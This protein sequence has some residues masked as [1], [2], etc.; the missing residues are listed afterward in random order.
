MK[1][2]DLGELTGLEIAVIGMA[3]RFPGAADLDKF[4]R[5]LQEG[6]ESI[7][8]FSNREL[9]EAGIATDIYTR[10]DY[11][12]AKG[13][14]ENIEYFDA[15]FFGYPPAEAT[16]MNP[17]MR[18]LHE[19]VWHAFEHAGIVPSS[20][21]GLIG[22]YVGETLSPQWEGLILL[23]SGIQDI[24]SL[25]PLLHRAVLSTS[26]S[27]KLNLH[28]PSFSVQTACSTSLVAIHLACQGL[29]SGDCD[30]AAAGGV[31][32]TLPNKC[33]YIYKKGMINSPDGHCRAFD[34]RAEGTVFGN[35]VGTVVLK[36]LE[37]AL[38]G[39]DHII[40]VIRGS[41]INN[42]GNRKA[43]LS[44]PSIDGEIE[45]I[46]GALNAAGAS[47]DSIGY[48]EAHGTG[49]AVGD[50]I[51]VEALHSVFG[52][53]AN[54]RCALGS[55][56][57][58]IGHLDVAAGVAGFIKTALALQ[59][60]QIPA[61]LNFSQPNSRIDFSKGPFYINTSLQKWDQGDKPLRAGVSSFGIGGTNAHVILEEFIDNRP[62]RKHPGQRTAS[63]IVL[64][65]KT[66]TA[67][68]QTSKNL[69]AY[70]E[71]NPHIDLS[72]A[73]YTL[74][75]GRT[76]FACRQALTAENRN[77]AINALAY[78]D[79]TKVMSGS[80]ERNQPRRPVI[81]LFPG[82]GA[83]YVSM[84]EE[85][86]RTEPVFRDTM[87]ECFH[88][89]Q[90][91]TG[92][93]FKPYLFPQHPSEPIPP[94][95]QTEIAQPLIFTIEYALAQLLKSWGIEPE[96]SIGH[97]I[98]EYTAACISG[99]MTLEVALKLI[100]SRGTL[101]QKCAP[102]GMIG[103]PLPATEAAALIEDMEL[104]LAAENSPAHCVVSGPKNA[105][106]E[107]EN[108]LAQAGFNG[109]NLHT[110]H[111]FHSRMMEPIVDKFRNIVEHVA[112]NPPV[113][114]FISNASGDWI[115]DGQA[116]DPNYWASHIVNT[117]RF[118]DGMTEL[119]K[120]EH[121]VFLE[122]G[123][124]RTLSTFAKQNPGRNP[125]QPV[126]NLMP[127]PNETIGGTQFLLEKLGNLWLHGIPVDWNGFNAGGQCFRVPLPGYPFEGKR[128]W[129]DKKIPKPQQ[130]FFVPC[131]KQSPLIA[132]QC[133]EEKAKKNAYVIFM[134]QL[135][136]GEQICGILNKK[137][138]RT[139]KVHAGSENY[140]E[141]F[142]TLDSDGIDTT[143][144]I[145]LWNIS[146]GNRERDP[147]NIQPVNPEG[148]DSLIKIV[149]HSRNKRRPRHLNIVMVCD[150]LHHIAGETHTYPEKALVLGALKTIPQEHP[151]IDCC[152]IDLPI[153]D[154]QAPSI[155]KTHARNLLAE[156]DAGL[157]E[158]TVA[159]RGGT[160][161]IQSLEPIQLASAQPTANGFK[162]KGTYLITGGFGK[163]ASA[164]AEFLAKER[165]ARL[166]LT[167][168][169]PVPPR[170]D[171]SSILEG[172]IK[173]EGQA[174]LDIL[175]QT[176]KLESLGAAVHII[177][178]DISDY[179]TMEKEISHAESQL[180]PVTG[181]IH[182]AG[183][184][185]P[186]ALQ[187]AAS[188]PPDVLQR[189][190]KSK[191]YGTLVLEKIFSR[192]QPDFMIMMSSISSFLGGLGYTS[193][194]AANIF[195]DRYVQYHNRTNGDHWLSINWDNWTFANTGGP[196]LNHALSS[197]KGLDILCR[198]V[199]LAIEG[200]LDQI[201]VSAGNLQER[202]NRWV[203]PAQTGLQKEHPSEHP[204]PHAGRPELHTLY[205][206]PETG[207]QRDVAAIWSDIL[208]FGSLGINDDFFELGGDSFKA[209]TIASDIHKRMNIEIPL[210]ELFARPT[211][212]QMADY[213]DAASKDT[214]QDIQPVEDKE[215]YRLS[216]AQKRLF[217]L[218]QLVPDQTVYNLPLVLE[219]QGAIDIQQ[220][221]R[222][223]QILVSRHESLRTSFHIIDQ[224]PVQRIAA[225]VEFT[226][227]IGEP[228][229][230][231]ALDQFVRPFPLSQPPLLRA[232]LIQSGPQR[233]ILAVD[234]HH[235]VSDGISLDN[236]ITDFLN[237][238]SQKE[239][240]P[241]PLRY[242]YYA[243]W[244]AGDIAVEI[245]NKQK[246]F[247]LERFRHLPPTLEIPTDF[248]R[249]P[250][251]TFAGASFEF[252][253]GK[254]PTRALKK[255]AAETSSTL[256]IL[257]LA[258]LDILLSRLSGTK[259][260]V[261]GSPIAGRRHPGLRN[262]IGIFLNTLAMRNAPE[263]E[264]TVS[265]FLQETRTATIEAFENQDFQ[266]EE[267]VE[268]LNVPRNTSRNPL[269]D[270][271][272]IFQNFAPHSGLQE[273]AGQTGLDLKPIDYES[274]TSKFDFTLTAI[275]A[276][277]TD[278][279]SLRFHIEYS[280]SLFKRTTMDRLTEYFTRLVSIIPRSMDERIKHLELLSEGDK[281]QILE[282]FNDTALD[283]EQLTIQQIFDR[284]AD[285]RPDS[286]AL[287]SHDRQFSY[288]ALGAEGDRIAGRLKQEGIGHED[289]VALMTP[290]SEEMIT[291]ILGILKSGAAYL[292]LD[293]EFPPNR[294]N[295]ILEQSKASLLVLSE[296]PRERSEELQIRCE[297]FNPFQR[298][299]SQCEEVNRQDPN[300]TADMAYV[301]YT[302]GSTGNPKGV[303][304]EHRNVANFISAI[305]GAIPLTPG[306][307]TLAATT[308][309]F[310]IFVLETIVPLCRSQ[311]VILASEEEVMEPAL[312]ETLIVKHCVDI[313]QFTPS[314]LQLLIHNHGGTDFLKGIQTVMVGG[315]T[316]PDPLL[317]QLKQTYTGN[318]YNMYGP[319]ETTVWS[320]VKDLTAAPEITVGKPLANT[321]LL[322]LD[323]YLN[324]L[325]VG[326]P[327]ELY[328]GGS[329]VARGYLN[330]PQLTAEKFVTIDGQL[331]YK[332][333]DQ[334][335]WREDGDVE[336]IGRK[337]HQVKIRGYRVELT[338][339]EERLLQHPAIAEAAVI[340]DSA[341]PEDI[342]SLAAYYVPAT[343]DC[344]EET[345]FQLQLRNHLTAALPGYMIPSRFIRLERLP[346]TPNGKIDRKALPTPGIATGPNAPTAPVSC[347]EKSIV[348]LWE[349]ILDT[350]PIGTTDN[351]FILGGH[352]LTATIFI[353][354]L[355]SDMKIDIP[356]SAM[357]NH[358]TVQSL[359]AAIGELGANRAA[360]AADHD[361]RTVRPVE[362]QDYYPQSSAQ[363]RLLF[364]DRFEDAG[365]NYNLPFFVKLEGPVDRLRFQ[366][367]FTKLIR[368][369][370]AF[371]TY[372]QFIDGQPVQRILEPGDVEFGIQDI[373]PQGIKDH[374]IQEAI[375]GFI[376]PFDLSKA[377]LFRVG[378]ITVGENRHILILDMHH[379]I[380]DGTSVGI[381][382]DQ[383]T[384][385]FAGEELAPLPVQ[386]KDFA[387]WQRRLHES[388][389]IARQESYWR[390]QL[391][392]ESPH[393]SLPLDFP[394]PKLF[395]F[396]GAIH[397]FPLDRESSQKV[398]GQCAALGATL[399]VH[400]LT[401]F[402]I[403]LHKYTEQTDILVGSVTAGRHCLE[404]EPVVGMF[405]NTLVFRNQLNERQ[406]FRQFLARVK[407]NTI[408][409]FDNQDVP[410]EDMVK[411]LDRDKDPSR[412]PLFDVAFVAQN[413]KPPAVHL[414]GLTLAPY[415][416]V[417]QTSKFDITLFVY[418]LGEE[419]VFD[420]EYAT[421]LYKPET[422]EK[423]GDRYIEVIKQILDNT[424]IPIKEISISHHLMDADAAL[425]RDDGEDFDF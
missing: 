63:L 34:H 358:P 150:S 152:S 318:I 255:L 15:S 2:D 123:P 98:G 146:T 159:F 149:K 191:G 385:F 110:S 121:A 333:G 184:L 138:R 47:P 222:T 334:A 160:R 336:F 415:E 113:I 212:K 6:V 153:L 125:N 190:M 274:R 271:M 206:P 60:R 134:D 215:Y 165:D 249:P 11:I 220:M 270:I 234:T 166:I 380:A 119:L 303:A 189:Q 80:I 28:G 182:A 233:T 332:T 240:A 58:N 7:H 195:M 161:W 211:I 109:R 36:P 227:E 104:S 144:I 171:W 94:I 229:V 85:L 35:G 90:R 411:L 398:R 381:L 50:P 49:T 226:I 53:A 17:Q 61:S 393:L 230:A 313:M 373:T 54:H 30:I 157:P 168:R 362:K 310:D 221:E 132:S 359:V 377:P 304:I 328:I 164:L 127:H 237:I 277:D 343:Q 167:T 204:A 349:E 314:R 64:S 423:I 406:N 181:V 1:A 197:K 205:A 33:G 218:Q 225:A 245:M 31:S 120:I 105:I 275:E 361:L 344:R 268:T 296:S 239:T 107:F 356:L 192:R 392:G 208:G 91:L 183:D 216:P 42:D 391:Q 194:A 262:T 370:E 10:P 287:A 241:P 325:P 188:S 326:C 402:N 62:H 162:H 99:V 414:E 19:N 300:Q 118:G 56:K 292:P 278:S 272:F 151:D 263:G 141:L 18:L 207:I 70:L 163:I 130:E 45:V 409:A 388:G 248:R 228:P 73:A 66:K 246:T 261:I 235:I 3:C 187:P 147:Q 43:G 254:E 390:D 345:E 72:R 311:K 117:V 32:I 283:V 224:Q 52:D 338:E 223:F 289:I 286:I 26:I 57:T 236:L 65:A 260:I 173:F 259:D 76:P 84:G 137:M 308:I 305:A 122:V 357:F 267:L 232:A 315:E 364:L 417:Y 131:W 372:F 252:V 293:P 331:Y 346:M 186:E 298:A 29:L 179:Q 12:K 68:E 59:Q 209:I 376:R 148:Y 342:K 156:I 319:T 294:I 335:R 302:S 133:T 269:F 256:Y 46:N 285:E 22:L 375:G 83:Q 317:R 309:S 176:K 355:R 142:R 247:W 16:I 9:A 139:I 410:F 219:L 401:A 92:K 95:N 238:Y 82:Q 266:F 329:G 264:K 185:S 38:A 79:T 295:Y 86:Y 93:A 387:V 389:E 253:M 312:L 193:Y 351:F 243:E 114:P 78:I 217:I 341:G 425:H 399:F 129:I 257:L 175:S 339:I 412:N 135:G 102:G 360:D 374:H 299:A 363:K 111:A 382:A 369:Q 324:L 214:H 348:R 106:G 281:Q 112:L 108:R 44:A 371:R 321:R 154:P 404:L 4:W 291:G 405:V 158:K 126:L 340:A 273:A 386:Y 21:K 407:E 330:N 231:E 307:T 172:H 51:E 367:T 282:V 244:L 97:S 89:L 280:S 5:N 136:L 279:P 258:T 242:R 354:R 128:Y 155:L 198:L 100:S 284:Q 24:S 419:I 250:V 306:Q 177:S 276:G 350:S 395:Q 213:I 124:G 14:L 288:R 418:D 145:H 396:D 96:A 424:D 400:L 290:R 316:F 203:S 420:L 169:R 378:L 87:D 200:T 265:A 170:R 103:V 13:N 368:H 178:A 55:V 88:I 37:E 327:G 140:D 365:T 397:R 384:R 408:A 297:R 199:P 301:I 25:G 20:Y 74:Q 201:I 71:A 48:I 27:Y 379:I 210:P 116:I 40:A 383:M 75:V 39:R 202:I 322:I 174:V 81:F 320:S 422:M 416:H 403:L 8:F 323:R 421:T 366:R 143:T 69:A 196:N 347:L 337:D 115:T 41:S 353:S 413:Y 23:S 101:M 77:E 394:R 67:L 352:S 180:G 251:Q